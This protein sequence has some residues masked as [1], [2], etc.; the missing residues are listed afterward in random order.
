MTAPWV[1]TGPMVVKVICCVRRRRLPMRQSQAARSARVLGRRMT[2][3]TVEP[4]K[5]GQDVRFLW[6]DILLLKWGAGVFDGPGLSLEHFGCDRDSG[7]RVAGGWFGQGIADRAE[8]QP[9]L[10]REGGS[11]DMLEVW[12]VC[13]SDG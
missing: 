1:G 10:R 13:F 2:T 6:S 7:G 3:S 8:G 12:R 4:A 9:I 11:T 5:E